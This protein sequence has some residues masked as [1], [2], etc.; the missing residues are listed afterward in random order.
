M[1]TALV[2]GGLFGVLAWTAAA[3]AQQAPTAAPVTE[4][5]IT[6]RDAV[7]VRS[8]P[9]ANYYATSKLRPGDRVQVVGQ[10][11]QPGWLKIK[12]P[13]GVSFSWVNHL[14]VKVMGEHTGFILSGEDNVPTVP[15]LAG[16]AV[17]NHTPDVEVNKLKRGY[18][19]VIL[20][21][22]ATPSQDGNW[23]SIQPT[24]G[25]V[26]YIPADAVKGSP[27][28]PLAAS[29][30]GRQAPVGG[31]S[32]T[33]TSA[34]QPTLREQA[35]Q[36]FDNRDWD[37]AKALYDQAAKQT[38]DYSEKSWCYQRL[39][40]IVKNG[41]R[42]AAGTAGQ[43]A[44]STMSLYRTGATA[45]PGATP[46][47]EPSAPRW[48]MWGKLRKTS[49]QTGSQPMYVLE[50]NQG[51]PLMYATTAASLSLEGYVGRLVCLY[52]PVSYGNEYLRAEYMTV[53]H[54]ALP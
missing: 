10:A 11:E 8:G 44:G 7:E 53:S 31:A 50:N 21:S 52:G 36:A 29:T 48:S 41:S 22:K 34:R 35:D 46:A 18:G 15:V 39:D 6:A 42:Q 26:R 32:A 38:D 16:S 1:R 33:V 45:G 4:M 3:R 17:N 19:V 25:E 24:E 23:L 54:V 2:L 12:P 51:Q 43:A 40:Q 28:T 30:P 9:G 37:R 14:Y 47:P 20:D 13:P 27:S 49:I 5:Q